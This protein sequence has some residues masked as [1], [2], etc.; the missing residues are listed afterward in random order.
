MRTAFLPRTSANFFFFNA[1][2]FVFVCTYGKFN[3]MCK[4]NNKGKKRVPLLTQ[5]QRLLSWLQIPHGVYKTS[6]SKWHQNLKY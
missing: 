2:T 3:H 1:H 4:Y 6:S 5:Q